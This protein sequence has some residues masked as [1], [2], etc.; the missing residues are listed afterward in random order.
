M[1]VTI[2]H[3]KF[4]EIEAENSMRTTLKDTETALN[5]E[6]IFLMVLHCAIPATKKY[7]IWRVNNAEPSDKGID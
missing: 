5:A 3:V 2:T 1:N 4:A 7:I 6:Q